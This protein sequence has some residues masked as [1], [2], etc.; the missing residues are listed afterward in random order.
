MA[1]ALAACAVP[2]CL[3]SWSW[4]PRA[5]SDLALVEV[6]AP[7]T[8]A[9]TAAAA[10]AHTRAATQTAHDGGIALAANVNVN[11]DVD[12]G[13]PA[14]GVYGCSAAGCGGRASGPERGHA[15]AEASWD[16]AC[17]QAQAQATDR[18]CFVTSCRHAC[19]PTGRCL[20]C[21]RAA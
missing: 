10:R 16:V 11:V 7:A 15:A 14:G 9:T 21:G 18:S 13:G 19:M 5:P 4:S 6:A 20:S 1:C 2:V 12:E 3:W 8:S 17:A